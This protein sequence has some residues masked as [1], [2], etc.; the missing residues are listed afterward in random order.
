MCHLGQHLQ[1]LTIEI[2][3]WSPPR[4]RSGRDPHF[5]LDAKLQHYAAVYF[6]YDDNMV[7]VME[8]YKLCDGLVDWPGCQYFPD[9]K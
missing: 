3:I 7:I 4:G 8:L 5:L 9:G 2:P 6:L 1:T